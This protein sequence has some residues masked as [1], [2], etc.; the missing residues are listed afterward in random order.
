MTKPLPHLEV[1]VENKIKELNK[2]VE[3][4]HGKYTAPEIFV[5]YTLKSSRVLGT[6]TMG[7][8]GDGYYHY[9][10]LNATLLN[11]LQEKYI[12]EVFVHEYAHACVENY[13]QPSLKDL[14]KGKKKPAA[15]GTE[16]KKFCKLFGISGTSTTKIAADIEWKTKPT[17]KTTKWSYTCGCRTHELSTVQ[18]NKVQSNKASYTCKICSQNLV[19]KQTVKA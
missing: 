3:D 13:C 2:I 9:I 6:H 14:M 18:H 19:F 17:R 15:H 5:N 1:L 16:F 4:I 7:F 8:V 12:D 11:T 10:S